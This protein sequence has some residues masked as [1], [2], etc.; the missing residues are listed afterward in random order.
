MRVGGLKQDINIH[1]HPPMYQTYLIS[2][3]S[4]LSINFVSLYSDCMHQCHWSVILH[5]IQA[6][7]YSSMYLHV[8]TL[9]YNFGTMRIEHVC[10]HGDVK[11][12]CT[13]H[14]CHNVTLFGCGLSYPHW[15]HGTDEKK[16]A[17]ISYS[18]IQ[19]TRNHTEFSSRH[20]WTFI[21]SINRL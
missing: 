13:P 6:S 12:D 21:S 2:Y 4:S 3:T 16:N 20:L 7:N 11:V 14:M 8:L 19:T 15:Y 17:C 10:S 5:I 9:R 1:L 18:S